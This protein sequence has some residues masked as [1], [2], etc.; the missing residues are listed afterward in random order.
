MVLLKACHERLE[1]TE[2]LAGCMVD[3][4][5][6]GKAQHV[7]RKIVRQRVYAIACG[8]PDGNNAARLADDPI[9][10]LLMGREA[11]TRAALASQPT[12]SR[13]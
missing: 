3:E 5:Q 1:L 11:L 9:H 2:R 8:Y 10:K 13:F 4:R 7:V 6:A 12:L